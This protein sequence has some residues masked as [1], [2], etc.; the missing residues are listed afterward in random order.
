MTES[1]ET[2]KAEEFA[3]AIYAAEELLGLKV[4]DGT[5]AKR[6]GVTTATMIRWSGGD[7]SDDMIGFVLRE[8]AKDLE[9][10]GIVIC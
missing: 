4:E 8:I 7:I 1:L 5:L 6:L 9:E 10:I 2:T 3:L